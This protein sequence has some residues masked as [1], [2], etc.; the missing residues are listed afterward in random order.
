MSNSKHP[1]LRPVI[2]LVSASPGI[3]IRASTDKNCVFVSCVHAESDVV[4]SMA[5]AY[6][7][8]IRPAANHALQVGQALFLLAHGEAQ[9][10]FQWL[11]ADGNHLGR[12]H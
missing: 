12:T 11:R 5:V 7:H 6:S 8:V 10:F 9:R 4:V 3:V 1:N 2:D